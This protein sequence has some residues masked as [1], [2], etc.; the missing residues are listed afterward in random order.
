[1]LRVFPSLGQYRLVPPQLAG[2]PW[3]SSRAVRLREPEESAKL[4]QLVRAPEPLGP[5]LRS[6]QLV[7]LQVWPE[8]VSARAV[9]AAVEPVMVPRMAL[10]QW[11]LQ[12][13][14]L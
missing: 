6:E 12:P 2:V 8:L 11:V 13:A 4:R 9:L 10:A 3:P 1:M 7:G 14:V 5:Q